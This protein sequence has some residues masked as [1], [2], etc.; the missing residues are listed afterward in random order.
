MQKETNQ[1]T[2]RASDNSFPPRHRVD[3]ST[4]PPARPP[5][6]IYTILYS[7]MQLEKVLQQQHTHQLLLKGK[8]IHL[9]IIEQINK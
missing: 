5:K 3:A 2:K 4:S 8:N 6:W 7:T 1:P 9:K